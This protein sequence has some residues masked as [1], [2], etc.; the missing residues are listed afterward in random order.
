MGR[1]DTGKNGTLCFPFDRGIGA[2]VRGCSPA[3]RGPWVSIYAVQHCWNALG[4]GPAAGGQWDGPHGETL[5]SRRVPCKTVLE[6]NDNSGRRIPDRLTFELKELRLK[7]YSFDSSTASSVSFLL[8]PPLS[9]SL[10]P[11]PFSFC[12]SFFATSVSLSAPLPSSFV[13]FAFLAFSF[14]F[15]FAPSLEKVS[16]AVGS[17]TRTHRRILHYRGAHFD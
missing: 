9:H 7:L 2:A 13:P 17:M 5:Y 16:S 15:F 4:P 14:L 10:S 8:I 1:S 6:V 11:S 3:T 12:S